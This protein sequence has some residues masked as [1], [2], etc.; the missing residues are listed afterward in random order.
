MGSVRP[1]LF[2]YLPGRQASRPRKKQKKDAV[3]LLLPLRL[4]FLG[5]FTS[6]VLG[7]GGGGGEREI[8][9]DDLRVKSAG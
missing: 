6:L 8:L 3:K 2:L 1:A 5:G 4:Y 9:V 7:R